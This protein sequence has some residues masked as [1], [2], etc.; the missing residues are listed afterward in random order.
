MHYHLYTCPNCESHFRV[1]WPQCLPNHLHLC[2][3]IKIKCSACEELTELYAFLLDKILQA[4]EQSIPTVQIESISP[5]DLKPDPDA[6]CKWQ[7]QIFTRRAARFKA[8]YG[9]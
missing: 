4:P 8:M 5:R 3:K 7:Q 2:S 6:R 1:V 9:N